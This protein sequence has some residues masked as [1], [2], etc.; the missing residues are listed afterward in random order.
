M[1]LKSWEIQLRMATL[2]CQMELILNITMKV[3]LM[4][5]CFLYSHTVTN[6]FYFVN[7]LQKLL[8]LLSWKL[9]ITTAPSTSMICIILLRAFEEH[10]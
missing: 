4:K 6:S 5:Y 8:I 3:C 1:R 10:Q 2:Q 7:S 9:A